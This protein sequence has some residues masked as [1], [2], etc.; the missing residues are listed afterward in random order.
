MS[1][2]LAVV[3]TILK[4]NLHANLKSE[5]SY[6]HIPNLPFS[7][8]RRRTGRGGVWGSEGTVGK[9]LPLYCIC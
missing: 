8:Q 7:Y 3:T 5:V 1:G 2:T 9:K 4:Y 6:S